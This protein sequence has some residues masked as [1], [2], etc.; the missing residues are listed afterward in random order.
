VCVLPAI[1]TLQ[2][3]VY[4]NGNINPF[5][6][7]LLIREKS[8]FCNNL[9][10]TH[11]LFVYVKTLEVSVLFI[12]ISSFRLQ[13]VTDLVE[14]LSGYNYRDTTIYWT[15]VGIVRRIAFLVL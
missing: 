14:V 1:P 3:I 12:I 4:P 10:T 11:E 6:K 8:R 2:F 15:K 5:N 7:K 13:V 9:Y